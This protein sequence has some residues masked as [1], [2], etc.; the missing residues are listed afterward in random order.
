M[1]FG[2]DFCKFNGKLNVNVNQPFSYYIAFL[3][4]HAQLDIVGIDH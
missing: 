4:G 3:M 1:F 2:S